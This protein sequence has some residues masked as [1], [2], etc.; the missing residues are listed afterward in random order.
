MPSV[1]FIFV[2]KMREKYFEGAF[3]EYL[4]RIGGYA[5]CEVRE[6]A[7][8]RLGE[9][10]SQRE[11]DAAL[12]REAQEIE[13]AVPK[14]AYVTAL[15][16]EGEMCSSEQLAQKFTVLDGRGVS[17]ICFIVGGSFGL[18]S[19]LKAGADWQLSMSKMTF[20]HHLARVMLAEQ[21]YRAFAINAGTRYHK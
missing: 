18:D 5:R 16:V 8:Q 2:G 4:K 11:I 19:A 17:R 12:A 3:A 20:P 1:S 14:G 6:V 9:R 13:K 21:V 10:P 15:C 7:E